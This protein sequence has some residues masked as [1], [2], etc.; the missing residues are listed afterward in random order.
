M[1]SQVHLSSFVH[2]NLFPFHLA[3]FCSPPFSALI[4]SE[5]YQR[6]LQ[7]TLRRV[8]KKARKQPMRRGGRALDGGKVANDFALSD[9][10]D[11]L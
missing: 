10:E 1:L 2:S 7:S 9:V 11:D 3:L 8:G 5:L 6:R 4:N